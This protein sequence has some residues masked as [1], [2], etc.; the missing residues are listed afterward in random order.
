MNK[1]SKVLVVL[2]I[3][4]AVAA[5]AIYPRID[6]IFPTDE[7]SIANGA[8]VRKPTNLP[9]NGHIVSP[10]LLENK[11]KV[12]GSILPNESLELKS[13][14]SGL[15]TKVHFKEGE[16]VRKGT[17]LISLKDDD[18][19]AQLQKLK[20]NKKLAEET[21][22]RQKQLLEKEA[23]SQEEYDISITA[24][25]S[26]DADISLINTQIARTSIIAPFDGTLG[27]R[28]ISEGAFIT[29]S[30]VITNFYNID[31]V[32]IDFSIPGKY[33][34]E[35]KIGDEIQ[36]TTESLSQV[37]KGT[38][39]AFEPQI[40]PTTRTLKLRAM[41]SN[42]GGTLLPGQF[43]RIEL[44][45]SSVDNALLV[46][47][48]SVIPEL[49]GHKVFIMNSGK[50]QSVTVKIGMRTEDSVQI[51]EGISPQDTVITTGLLEIRQGSMIS[52][53]SLTN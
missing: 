12:T 3:F 13:E 14:V 10:Q 20:I 50:A 48:V 9:V 44:I 16:K 41:T 37:Y 15:V 38:V 1:A 5:W 34:G 35:V 18:L 6:E 23:I 2:I 19:Q 39:Y 46:P 27:L 30:T 4:L 24:V 52:V 25:Y 21:E 49:N 28:F 43:A 33:A 31:P 7:S 36:F 32:K 22:K 51:L 53:S 26:L 42:K 17:L 29:N 45:M 8:T 47:A 40:D 11:I